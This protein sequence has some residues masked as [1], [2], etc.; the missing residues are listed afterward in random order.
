MAG[1]P[2]SVSTP[3]TQPCV[4]EA[5]FWVPLTGTQALCLGG[6]LRIR[7]SAHEKENVAV[8]PEGQDE[9]PL[10]P[11]CPRGKGLNPRSGQ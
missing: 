9:K 1:D 11:L 10:L 8:T 3:A 5:L 2:G 4:A 7:G 6:P